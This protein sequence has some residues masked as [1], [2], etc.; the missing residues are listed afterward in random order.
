MAASCSLRSCGNNFHPRSGSRIWLLRLPSPLRPVCPKLQDK[1]HFLHIL[2]QSAAVLSVCLIC[3]T[4]AAKEG[5]CSCAAAGST[6]SPFLLAGIIPISYSVGAVHPSQSKHKLPSLCYP[7]DELGVTPH[8]EIWGAD[9]TTNRK[10]RGIFFTE[11]V[12][13][14]ER[15]KRILSRT[16]VFKPLAEGLTL[17]QLTNQDRLCRFLWIYWETAAYCSFSRPFKTLPVLSLTK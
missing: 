3:W 5:S 11:I 9:G 7:R 6:T 8:G 4:W 17:R 15:E 16:E 14:L 10:I 13:Y 12:K 1:T 2:C